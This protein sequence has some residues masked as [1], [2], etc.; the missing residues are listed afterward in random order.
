[1]CLM[2]Q[3]TLAKMFND[4][5]WLTLQD[6]ALRELRRMDDILNLSV[7]NAETKSLLHV[8]RDYKLFYS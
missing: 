1:M 5:K 6:Y 4:F 2:Y 3:L 8:R 7:A